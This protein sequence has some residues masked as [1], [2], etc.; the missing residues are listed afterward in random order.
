MH[1]VCPAEAPGSPGR[2]LPKPGSGTQCSRPRLEGRVGKGGQGREGKG[3]EKS[4]GR[5][6]R[7]REGRGR[8]RVAH[9]VCV[10]SCVCTRGGPTQCAT[11]VSDRRGQPGLLTSGS[12]PRGQASPSHL[13]GQSRS[14]GSLG[15]QLR[16]L[17]LR[18]P[19]PKHCQAHD[20]PGGG[21][22]QAGQPSG[23]CAATDGEGWP[24]PTT[25]LGAFPTL[26]TSPV[27]PCGARSGARGG[28]G[29]V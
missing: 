4:W 16:G 14:S 10:C 7:G 24:W 27:R 8:D 25:T 12:P 23:H 11:C 1:A 29:R 15:G 13:S 20:R 21:R 18:L 2:R 6:G 28:Q 26:W 9:C 3:R 5:E 22:R 17:G 19:P